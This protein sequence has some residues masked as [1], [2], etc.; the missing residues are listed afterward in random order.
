MLC[1]WWF[2]Q[3]HLLYYV[4]IVEFFGLAANV[5]VYVQYLCNCAILCTRFHTSMLSSILIFILWR[6]MGML[7]F[8]V[9]PVLSNWYN[10][11]V[12]IFYSVFTACRVFGVKCLFAHYS[13]LLGL[14]F[15]N[16]LS[17]KVLFVFF[18]V[19]LFGL[20]SSV[21]SFTI[22]NFGDILSNSE[23]LGQHNFTWDFSRSVST[24]PNLG[25]TL[26]LVN[27]RQDPMKVLSN[28]VRFVGF[29]IYRNKQAALQKI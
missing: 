12:N 3:S 1:W 6:E 26:N 9:I 21:R 4:D 15:T 5:K 14:S 11:I 29:L 22:S 27:R 7:F 20:L 2:F 17:Y 25:K 19:I 10:I 28:W 24:I 13:R 23:K 16:S 18:S 8:F